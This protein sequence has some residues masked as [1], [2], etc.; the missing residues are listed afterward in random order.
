MAFAGSRAR[1]DLSILGPARWCVLDSGKI[2][3]SEGAELLSALSLSERSLASKPVATPPQKLALIGALLLLIGFFLPW[4]TINP[5]TELER[6]AQR[7]PIDPS[8]T[9]HFPWGA[10]PTTD[11]IRYVGGDIPHGLGWLILFL[12]VA[13]AALPYLAG[14][15]PE[16][17]RQRATLGG[18]GVGAVILLYLMT[19]NLRFVS[20]GI[21][22]AMAGYGLQ[23][24]CAL[25][26]GRFS[27]HAVD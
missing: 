11:A 20:I 4:I 2:T 23:L 16:P 3:A 8:W 7:L 6:A 14:N 27:S 17:T 15:L 1:D 25:Q 18:L 12:G 19:N 22:L 10:L 26:S 13:A 24:A 5:Q 9:Q 21:L